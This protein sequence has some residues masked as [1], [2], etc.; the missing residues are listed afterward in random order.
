METTRA[1]YITACASLPAAIS[2]LGT[3]TMLSMPLCAPY[4]AAE[5]LVLPVDA[6][7]MAVHSL[8]Q[9]LGHGQNHAAILE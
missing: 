8:L 9:G 7:M 6:Q 3:I 5:A 4:A 2:P 1:P